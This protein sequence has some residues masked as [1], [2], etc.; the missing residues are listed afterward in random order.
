MMVQNQQ[1]SLRGRIFWNVLGLLLPLVIALI[2]VPRLISAMGEVRF[3]MLSLVFALL[4]YA[5]VFDLGVG[6]AV[7]K[8]VAERVGGERAHEIPLYARTA[9]KIALWFGLAGCVLLLIAQYSGVLDLI[10]ASPKIW[11]EFSDTYLL[12]ALA[13]PLVTIGG[14]LRGI[15]EGIGAF[16]HIAYVRIF[17]GFANFAGPLLVVGLDKP[18]FAATAAIV[19]ARLAA[20]AALT[21]FGYNI[22]RPTVAVAHLD[23][24]IRGMLSF[25]G[26][27]TVSN[28]I[29]PAMTYLDRF[30]IASLISATA[31]AYYA[32]PYDMVTQAVILPSAIASVLFPHFSLLRANDVHKLKNIYRRASTAIFFIMVFVAVP[33]IVFAEPVIAWWISPGFAKN[34]APVAQVLAFGLLFNGMAQLPFALL[35]ASHRADVT[36]KLHLI[37]ALIYFLLLFFLLKQLGIIGAAA[38]WSA[39]MFLDYMAL[40]WLARGA[41]L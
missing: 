23:G 21:Y 9:L 19:F 1:L 13:I 18:L 7:T 26:W 14:V 30:V 35:H 10:E 2:A 33:V 20:C 36:A 4:G 5:S 29:S 3:G 39:R 16:R 38:A 25:G 32:T 27:M 8:L 28:I 15:L 41:L 17:N 12:C 11:L 40:R 34:A 37:E 6:R 31:V 22:L 24:V